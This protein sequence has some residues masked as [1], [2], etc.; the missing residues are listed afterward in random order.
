MIERHLPSSLLGIHQDKL[1]CS[2]PQIIA[3]P[4]TSIL[5]EPMRRDLGFVHS[6]DARTKPAKSAA[7]LLLISGG[8][9]IRGDAFGRREPGQRSFVR[10]KFVNSLRAN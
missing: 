10:P 7:A 5:R 8:R 4:E 6:L 9:F 1:F 3:I 2:A